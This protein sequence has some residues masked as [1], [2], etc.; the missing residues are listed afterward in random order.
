MLS[1]D[2]PDDAE[3]RLESVA[4]AKGQ[5]LVEYVKEVVLAALEDAEDIAEAEA[6]LA[7]LEAG[8]DSLISNEEIVRR[9]SGDA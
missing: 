8:R 5:T 9:Y 2:L 6:A 1:V 7:D 3:S 4:Q